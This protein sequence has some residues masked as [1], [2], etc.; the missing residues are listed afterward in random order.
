MT[1]DMIVTGLKFVHV[2]TIALWSAGLLALPFLYQQ[3]RGLEGD[4]LH[5]L[6]AFTRFFYINLV[7]AGAFAAI[8]SGTALILLR[9]TYENWFSAKLLAVSVMTGVHIFSGLLILRLFEK[10]GRYP[11]MRFMITVPLTALSVCAILA[12]VLGKP[13]L[14]WPQSWQQF[15]APGR[16]SEMV[17]AFIA[18]WI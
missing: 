12:L 4:A 17:G 16:L 13:Q 14:Q 15:F 10:S 6:H 1:V 3:R 7:S 11:G 8:A 18:G 9:E 2:G 5:R